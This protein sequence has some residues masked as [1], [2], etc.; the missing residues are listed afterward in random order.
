MKPFALALALLVAIALGACG[1]GDGN[2]GSSTQSEFTPVPGNS[3]LVV[4]QN[5]FALGLLDQENQPLLEEPGTSVLLRF[6]FGEELKTEQEA[7]FVWAIEDVN[8]FYTADVDF[9]AAGQWTADAVITRGGKEETLTFT[10]PVLEGTD[11]PNVGDAAPPTENLTLASEPN[12]LRLSTDDEP[13]PSFYQLTVTEALQ[14]N[15]P[16]VIVFATPAF[17]ATRFCGPVVDNV[18]AVK[19]DYADTVNFIHIEPYELN[20]EGEIEKNA[21]GQ[22]V[23]RQPMSD[24]HLRTEPWVYVVDAS[25]TISARFEGP[26]SPQELRAAIDAAIA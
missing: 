6:Y 11:T 4:G 17:C 21:S 16:F 19:A 12:I 7:T 2:G 8:G 20:A 26:A 3:E 25:G 15:K 22:L 14:Q 18:Q 10:F 23:A 1:G 24:W 13:D 9:D 5:R